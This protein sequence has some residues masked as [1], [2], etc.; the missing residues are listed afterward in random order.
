MARAGNACERAAP[1]GVYPCRSEDRWIAIA[2]ASDPEWRLLRRALSDP[3]FSQD[4]RFAAAAGRLEHR[5][6]LDAYLARFT[7]ERDAYELMHALQAVGLEAG[8]A[9]RFDDLLR[10]P[11]LAHRGHFVPL[12]HAQLGEAA[13]EHC[14][15]RLSE[16][17]PRLETPG[18][19]LG[20]HTGEVLRAALGLTDAEI[21]S[22]AERQVLV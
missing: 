5:D 9:Q 21:A 19:L 17:P 6:E 22:L 4:P 18:P 11:Q 10:D 15:L 8:V 13:F 1:H 12:R 2:I 7:R 3:P 14:G 16:S 20:E